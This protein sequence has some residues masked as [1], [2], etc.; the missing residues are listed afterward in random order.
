[1]QYFGIIPPLVT[2]LLDENTLDLEG[3]SNLIN[4][5]IDGGVHGLFILGTT[6]EAS[7]LSYQLKHQFIEE[8]CRIVNKRI[9][10]LVGITDPA[11]TESYHLAKTSEESGADAVIAAPPF[12]F[13]LGQPE[14]IEYY[15]LLLS[16]IDLPL[17]LYNMPVHTKINIEPDTV[18]HLSKH[19][20]L[21]GLKDSSANNV[22]LNKIKHKL[23]NQTDFSLF[24]GAEE[25]LA[26]S[27][28]IGIDGGVVGGANIFPELYVNTY[29]S[30]KSGDIE[31]AKKYHQLI[32]EVSTRLY[33]VGKF[34]SSY[35]KG[36]KS[37]LGALGICSDFMAS[38]LHHFKEQ[39]KQLIAQRVQE[40]KNQL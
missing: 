9:P 26:E 28:L 22:Y 8:T 39:E 40:I 27:V 32:L 37:S 12:Y 14:L 31:S 30:A 5:V 34:G 24:V 33:S 19:E 38:P 36:V 10:V 29:N 21:I 20:N 25:I 13:S 11:I 7:S 3:L 17:F 6:G 4:H 2:P 15:E 16:Q 1:M 23:T 35:L 18:V